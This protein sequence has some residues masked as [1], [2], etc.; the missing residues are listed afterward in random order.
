VDW[1]HLDQD[2]DQLQAPVNM[3]NDPLGFI[4]YE[5]FD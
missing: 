5:E 4:K 1:M 3:V 2:K